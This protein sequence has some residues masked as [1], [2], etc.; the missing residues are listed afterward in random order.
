[1][2]A[3]FV[4]LAYKAVGFDELT[5]TKFARAITCSTSEGQI[6]TI[7]VGGFAFALLCLFTLG[8]VAQWVEETRQAKA[9][10]RA[11]EANPWRPALHVAGTLAVG[12]VGFTL[13]NLWCQ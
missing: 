1:M 4:G 8:E 6:G 3:L 9:Q 13:M 7:I 12:T 11:S 5:R 10:G 2:V